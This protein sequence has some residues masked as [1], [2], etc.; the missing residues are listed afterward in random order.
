[1][2]SGW[3]LLTRD[4]GRKPVRISLSRVLPHDGQTGLSP[5]ARSTLSSKKLPKLSAFSS[6]SIRLIADG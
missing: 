2:Y 4:A 5:V 1:M 6:Q 3:F